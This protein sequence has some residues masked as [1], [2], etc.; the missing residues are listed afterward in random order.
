MPAL[1]N[2]VCGDGYAQV[3]GSRCL[4][5]SRPAWDE[6][7]LACTPTPSGPAISALEWLPKVRRKLW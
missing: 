2:G 1:H 3:M 4:A 6:A 7:K 5:D